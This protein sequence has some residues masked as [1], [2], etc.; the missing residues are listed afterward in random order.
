MR[1]L[2]ITKYYTNSHD[3]YA[4]RLTPDLQRKYIRLTFTDSRRCGSKETHSLHKRIRLRPTFNQ[5]PKYLMS[6]Q[7]N[8]FGA[9][10]LSRRF[11]RLSKRIKL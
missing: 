7:V 8:I 10:M 3:I 11:Q 2:P 4:L 1:L 5:R 6:R 9:N